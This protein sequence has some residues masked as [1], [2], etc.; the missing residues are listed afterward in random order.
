MIGTIIPIVTMRKKCDTITKKLV[1]PG[2]RLR[3]GKHESFMT[4][5]MLEMIAKVRWEEQGRSV[6][7]R[8][9]NG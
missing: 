4:E 9:S 5:A 3:K 7:G 8:F 2:M 6:T 1:L